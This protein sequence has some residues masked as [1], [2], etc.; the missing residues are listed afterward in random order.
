MFVFSDIKCTSARP[1]NQERVNQALHN[2]TLSI[3]DYDFYIYDEEKYINEVS[4]VTSYNGEMIYPRE[5]NPPYINWAVNT[6][7]LHSV[8]S[9]VETKPI[10]TLRFV[11]SELLAPR[12]IVADGYVVVVSEDTDEVYYYTVKN[13]IIYKH[14][15]RSMIA[16]SFYK[17][18]SDLIIGEN[19][20]DQ[21]LKEA[22]DAS[23]SQTELDTYVSERDI[24]GIFCILIQSI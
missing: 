4:G 8:Y 10:S 12:D 18:I 16:T 15:N 9:D 3:Q 14:I 7:G 19:I 6:H 13:N 23:F 5:Y 2:M 24:Y 21:E 1:Y 11:L 17:G 22:I 20:K